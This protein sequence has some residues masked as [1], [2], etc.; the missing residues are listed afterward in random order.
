VPRG[1]AVVVR[2]ALPPA[3]FTVPS[4]VD[5]ELNVTVPVGVT[6]GEATVAAYFSSNVA[7]PEAHEDYL[8]GRYFWNKRNRDSLWKAI[9][10]F[11]RATQRE[12]NYASAYAGLAD[13]YLVLGNGFI[14]AEEA[15]PKAR[16]AARKALFLDETNAE[17][18]ASLGLLKLEDEND[19]E[20]AD[21]ELRRSIQLNPGYVT[22]HGWHAYLLFQ[23]GHGADAVPEVELAVRLNPLYPLSHSRAGDVYTDTHQFDLAER[24]FQRAIELDPNIPQVHGGLSYLRLVEG[25]YAESLDEAKRAEAATGTISPWAADQ[26]FPY[27]KIGQRDQAERIL[28]AFQQCAG[29]ANVTAYSFVL[30]Y[31]GV[32]DNEKAMQA[33][34]T[35]FRD[36]SFSVWNF[37]EDVR[38]EELRSD[39]RFKAY[40]SKFNISDELPTHAQR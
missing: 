26:A 19:W 39:P 20:G 31:L 1:K 37:L 5:P 18:H 33:L 28:Q 32:G 9:Q 25:R 23:T 6:V 36:R 38:L 7:D 10:Y 12:P 24:A 13:A 15:Y 34:P 22:A 16:A 2:L 21:R 17:A 3:K 27:G 4:T 29:R 30:T 35:A 40:R 11:E 14:A 8:K